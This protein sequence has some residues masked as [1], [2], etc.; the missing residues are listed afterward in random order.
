MQPEQLHEVKQFTFL[1]HSSQGRL[2]EFI[3]FG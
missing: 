1:V 3:T 2:R